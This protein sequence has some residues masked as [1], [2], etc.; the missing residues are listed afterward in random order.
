MN[1]PLRLIACPVILIEAVCRRNVRRLV[2]GSYLI[3]Y[4]IFESNRLIE[5][6]RF[7]HGA[8]ADLKNSL[9]LLRLKY[10]VAGKRVATHGLQERLGAGSEVRLIRRPKSVAMPGLTQLPADNYR[11]CVCLLHNVFPRQSF[12]ERLVLKYQYL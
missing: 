11:F 7:W 10:V 5:V 6:L 9:Q 8:A 2:H 3:V 1:W 4:R 12:P